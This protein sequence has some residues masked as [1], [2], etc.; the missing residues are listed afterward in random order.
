[1]HWRYE[2][3]YLIDFDVL[4]DSQQLSKNYL[5]YFSD[6]FY[7]WMAQVGKCVAKNTHDIT[8]LNQCPFYCQSTE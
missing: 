8:K 1:M 5:D 4:S 6:T 3:K 7:F 2:R